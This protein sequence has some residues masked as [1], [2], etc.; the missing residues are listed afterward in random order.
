MN[1]LSAA[2]RDAFL[3]AKALQDIDQAWDR[4]ILPQ[5]RDYIAIPAKS[6][7]FDPQ[8]AEHGHIEAV[9]RHAAAWV[10]AQKITGLQ[11]EIL[12]L[13]GRTPVLFFE[14]PASGGGKKPF[15]A[16]IGRSARC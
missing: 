2:A 3:P 8:W 7:M 1:A 11:L 14:V 4:E 6:P 10:A 12:R 13:D 9:V 16:A 5:L 15:K